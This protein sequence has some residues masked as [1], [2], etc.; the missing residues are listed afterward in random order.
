M[1]LVRL[2]AIHPCPHATKTWSPWVGGTQQYIYTFV[3]QI[4]D[5]LS[6]VVLYHAEIEKLGTINNKL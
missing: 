1:V 6:L 2:G 4:V 3:H 5:H